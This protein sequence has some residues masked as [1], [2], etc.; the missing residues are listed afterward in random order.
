MVLTAATGT[1]LH[2]TTAIY[3]HWHHWRRAYRAIKGAAKF[4]IT[5][6]AKKAHYRLCGYVKLRSK[7]ITAVQAGKSEPTLLVV[8]GY[9]HPDRWLAINSKSLVFQ[10][11][12]T[13]GT[14]YIDG[15]DSFILFYM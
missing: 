9:G 8:R 3:E 10:A 15:E 2:Y 14:I 12:I 6:R 4:Q 1:Y 11:M 5:M 13:M 7:I